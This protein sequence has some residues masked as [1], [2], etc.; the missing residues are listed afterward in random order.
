MV[1]GLYFI[2]DGSGNYYRVNSSDQLVAVESRT[3]A[4]VFS[5]AEANQKI[6]GGK[7]AQFY[8]VIPVEEKE[9]RELKP[10]IQE[11]QVHEPVMERTTKTETDFVY[12][13]K[14]VNWEEYLNH[15]CYLVCGLKDYQEELKQALSDIDMQICDIMHYIELY[16]LDENESIRMVELL[17]ECR[18]Q[19]RD[20]KD[21]TVRVE[22]FQKSIGTSA[23]VAKVKD[24]MKQIKKLSTRM[25]HPRKLPTLFKTCMGETIR[26]NKLERAMDTSTCIDAVID[27]VEQK[28][29]DSLYEVQVAMEENAM[30]YTKQETVFDVQ[31]NNWLQFAKQQ[32]EFYANAEQYMINLQIRQGEL[33][34]ELEE[35][36]N[37]VENANYNVTQG[38]SVYKRLKELRNTKK[39]LQK[40]LDALYI[41]TYGINC[42]QMA[43]NMSACVEELGALYTEAVNEKAISEE[44]VEKLSK[45][46]SVMQEV[47]MA[48]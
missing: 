3:Y 8:S 16:D 11:E 2:V 24:S 39:K 42:N 34:S 48:G 12:D 46:E 4:G 1:S 37:E 43:E 28:V 6:G 26:Q 13:M 30:E 35:L 38:Y 5:F 21:E 32:A 23:N 15:F 41:L 45:Q 7:K 25:Y 22:Y 10:F 20:V 19:R 44:I 40:E 47:M 18:E 27:A 29:E 31:E 17:K 14:N 33:D 36:L 9:E